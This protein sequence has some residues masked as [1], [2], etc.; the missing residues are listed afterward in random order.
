MEA[1]A[2]RIIV[3]PFVQRDLGSLKTPALVTDGMAV[4]TRGMLWYVG[5]SGLDGYHPI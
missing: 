2:R 3:Y 5:L 4:N 1:Q